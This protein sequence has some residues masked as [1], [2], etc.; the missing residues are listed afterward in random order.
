MC[1]DGALL[2]LDAALPDGI[3]TE[4]EKSQGLV[5]SS[6]VASL[7]E[8]YENGLLKGQE[9][10]LALDMLW[11]RICFLPK[12]LHDWVNAYLS[13]SSDRKPVPL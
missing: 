7:L 3:A 11:G 10:C 2:G 8:Q 1:G 5:L 6:M 4:E 13:S 12:E 9:V